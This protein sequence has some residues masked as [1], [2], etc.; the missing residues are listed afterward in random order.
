[1]ITQSRREYSLLASSHQR[2]HPMKKH[3]VII[4]EVHVSYLR[5]TSI[6]DFINDFILNFHTAQISASLSS[7]FGVTC[8][9]R[10]CMPAKAAVIVAY[11]LMLSSRSL[12]EA[13]LYRNLVSKTARMRK[14]KMSSVL[15]A[16]LQSLSHFSFRD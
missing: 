13:L 4:R 12:T 7:V 16:F 3:S 8:F 2:A 5:T 9:E 10:S 1:M 15:T 14:S 11:L 6:P